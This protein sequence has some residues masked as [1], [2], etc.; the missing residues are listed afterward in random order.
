VSQSSPRPPRGAP[1]IVI[2][3]GILLL[4]YYY[5]RAELITELPASSFS[6]LALSVLLA[7]P[8]LAVAGMPLVFLKR[9]RANPEKL[10]AMAL[11]CYGAMGLLSM[12]FLGVLSRD[13][14]ALAMGGASLLAGY[15]FFSPRL[16]LLYGSA[17]TSITVSLSLV[18]YVVAL[19][20]SRRTPRISR[21]EVPLS[22]LSPELEGFKIAQISDLHVGPTIKRAYVER[23]VSSVNA[24]EPDV[25]AL[26]G[27]IVDGPVDRLSADVA[28]LGGLSARSGIYYVTGNHEYYWGGPAWVD[29]LKKLGIIPLLNTHRVVERGKA[30][31]VIAGVPDYTAH[32]MGQGERPS[33]EKA[34]EGASPG[35]EVKVLLVHQ[36]KAAFAAARLGFHLQLS[37]HTHG[38][39]FL[40]WTFVIY[41]F[42]TFVRG[43]N[44]LGDMWVYVSRGTGSWGPPLRL[45]ASSEITLLTLRRETPEIR[46]RV[47]RRVAL[48]PLPGHEENGAD[49]PK[50]G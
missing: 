23:V 32:R 12:L 39:Q 11:V 29:V 44:R 9:G 1:F 27:D 49:F 10:E 25:V 22:N 17:G 13:I 3:L 42:H 31:L 24:L 4:A 21:I 38:G 46:A 19:L 45:G 26:T 47:C 2:L 36:P 5:L 41:F 7:L 34:L 6:R 48:K 43:L 50:A 37:G 40:P 15:G 18:L 30:Q 16:F 33:P 8:F 35:A 28:P 20:E 14:L